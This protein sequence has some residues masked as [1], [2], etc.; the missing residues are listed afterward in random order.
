MVIYMILVITQ[1]IILI[2]TYLI[3][4]YMVFLKMINIFF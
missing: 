4:K 3:K 2:T 1:K